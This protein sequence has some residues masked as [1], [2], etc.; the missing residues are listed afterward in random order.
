MHTAGRFFVHAL[1]EGIHEVN[2]Q[3]PRLL[4]PRSA[5]PDALVV[6]LEETPGCWLLGT[7][8]GLFTVDATGSQPFA[9]SLT[10]FIEKHRLT[11]IARL[12]DGR[13]AVG[14]LNGG[15]AFLAPD[16]AIEHLLDVEFE[17]AV[18]DFL[19]RPQLRLESRIDGIDA[20]WLRGPGDSGRTLTALRDGHYTIRVRALAE[21]GAPGPEKTFSFHV[22]RPWWRTSPAIGGLMVLVAASAAGVSRWRMRQ[23]RRRNAELEQKISERTE[24]LE[25]AN[26]AK[27]DFVANMSHDIR[28]PLN[29]IVGLAIAL[30]NTR[31]D[32][33]QREMVATLRE[34]S[35]YLSSLVDDVLDFA[36][37]ET[38]KIELRPQPFAPE[39][40]LRSVAVTM[41]AQAHAV[42]APLNFE[43]DATLPP[44]V[45]GDAGRIQQILVNFVSNAVK[46]ACGEIQLT[47]SRPASA[48][49]EI[50]LAVSD[51][52]P[53]LTA[54][55][56]GSLFT[57]F[58][59]LERNRTERIPG[60][61]LGLAACR[62]LADVMGGAVG[63]TSAP[64]QGSRFFL[65]LP[66]IVAAPENHAPV[67]L[68]NRTIL[69]VEDTD[70][71]A[72]A[73]TAVLAKLGLACERARTGAEA[74]R[75]F[76]EKRFNVVMLDCNLPDLDGIEVAR[77]MRAQEANE[78]PALLLA[79]T[80]YCTAADRERCLA[81]GMDAFVGKPIT[82]EK[83]RRVLIDAGR[84][85]LT[86][87]TAELA[88][89]SARS[90]DVTLLTYLSDGTPAGL[91]AHVEKFVASLTADF[92]AAEA[93]HVAADFPR[94]VTSAHRLHGHAKM[95]G[96]VSLAQ[97]SQDLE[98]AA[99]A[100]ND[101]ECRARLQDI[102]R[103]M[104]VLTGALRRNQPAEM[105]V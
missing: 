86:T 98:A 58:S 38:G 83:I 27:T 103:E 93:A 81:A 9:P 7:G 23:L 102:R 46:Y 64:G 10:P 62:L 20:D 21:A 63:V 74:L 96:G 69:L 80:A 55:E 54:E 16:G 34:C 17:F 71:N 61:G 26:A 4:L 19:R 8:A 1:A 72:W 13:L 82:P 91:D 40:L 85:L 95:V 35:T 87:A 100:K 65:R 41:Q 37:I 3:G 52:G 24:E 53:G 51:R 6:W 39:E 79:V 12:R 36:T 42:A 22:L 67:R 99:R 18:P 2:A 77:R 30:E 101:S 14:S 56:Q 50:E 94:L 45:L 57:K 49:D 70:Y 47:A 92:D 75:L 15:L 29:G 84:K 104:D 59:R 76:A 73:A 31:L 89:V 25:H 78:T 90:T 68:A 66:L 88:D 32:A 5:L 44:R 28:N 11:T 43:V 48:P 105:S 97:A 33:P 60:T